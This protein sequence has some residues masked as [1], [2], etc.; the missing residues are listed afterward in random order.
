[1]TAHP[2]TT[3]TTTPR[4]PTKDFTLR[5]PLE[6]AEVLKNQAFVTSKSINEVMKEA[7]VQYL[8]GDARREAFE[9]ALAKVKDDHRVALDKLADL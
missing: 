1:M 8:Q 9:M 6:L 7:L 2:T 4:Q 5:L 3:T